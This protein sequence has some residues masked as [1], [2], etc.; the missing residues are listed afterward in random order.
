MFLPKFSVTKAVLFLIVLLFPI[1]GCISAN[2]IVKGDVDLKGDTLY[3]PYCTG[4][5]FSDGIIRNGVIA[6]TSSRIKAPSDRMVFSDVKLCGTWNV[7]VAYSSW[8]DFD[9]TGNRDDSELAR[10]LFSIGSG[11]VEFADG[12]YSFSDIDICRDISIRGNDTEI[13]GVPKYPGRLS[14]NKD[15]FRISDVNTVE[16]TGISFT[17]DMMYP[18]IGGENNS[19]GVFIH[20]NNV[21]HVAISK[22]KFFNSSN[23]SVNTGDGTY[24][25]ALITCIDCNETHIDNCDFSKCIKTEHVYVWPLK[26]RREECDFFFTNNHI[27]GFDAYY[28]HRNGGE[29]NG[30]SIPTALCNNLYMEGNTYEDFVYKGSIVNCF[31]INTI[32]RNNVFRNC[33]ATSVFDGCEYGKFSGM[34]FVAQDN[35]IECSSA[36]AFL[37]KADSVII[38]NNIV[39][40][41]SGVIAKAAR[42]DKENSLS[43][44]TITGNVF[45][46]T[47]SDEDGVGLPQKNWQSALDVEDYSAHS[48]GSVRIV[49]NRITFRTNGVSPDA[50]KLM[51]FANMGQVSI[52]GNEI[53]AENF[54]IE[55][56]KTKKTYILGN[57]NSLPENMTIKDNRTRT[58]K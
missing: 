27:H 8:F 30:N 53:D 44:V 28:P 10:M 36:I 43:F 15:V 54:S 35:S 47:M 9:R 26:K 50:R 22:C 38:C 31:G 41:F 46:L 25:G 45:N 57:G 24:R 19:G 20:C 37:P 11:V 18:W 42:K 3:L 39:N 29:I 14:A 52:T 34:V 56:G 51:K 2:Y 7:D 1:C 58:I 5:N 17:G 21:T 40:A 13:R 4:I 16:I 23:A 6:G 12:I 48:G 32:V 55:D 49:G 33:K